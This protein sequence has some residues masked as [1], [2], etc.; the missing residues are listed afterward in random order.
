MCGLAGVPVKA[1]GELVTKGG[2][3]VAGDGYV[4]HDF[5]L[6]PPATDATAAERKRRQ[7]ALERNGRAPVR[8]SVTRDIGVTTSKASRVTVTVKPVTK[9]THVPCSADALP[10]GPPPS[11]PAVMPAPMASSPE[12]DMGGSLSAERERE[13]E[14]PPVLSSADAPV[15]RQ[16]ARR[17]GRHDP[18]LV[19]A[20]VTA[21]SAAFGYAGQTPAEARRLAQSARDLAGATDDAG[22]AAPV[23]PA[24]IAVLKAVWERDH[25]Y[26]CTPWTLVQHLGELRQ[27]ATGPPA[28]VGQRRRAGAEGDRF[29]DEIAIAR[30]RI[31]GGPR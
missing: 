30:A 21:L 26:A 1:I 8:R 3:D 25:D 24:E 13:R 10:H 29:V 12:T 28:T 19:A 14:G 27:L 2:F 16:L 17:A 11:R 7:R 9:E 5:A 23:Q 6:Y 20:L 15:D 4:V 31:D 18:A 22:G